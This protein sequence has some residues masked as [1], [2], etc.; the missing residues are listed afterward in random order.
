MI[1]SKDFFI[2]ASTAAHQVEGNNIHSDYW[3]ME[4]MEYSSFVEPSLDAVDHYNRYEEDIQMLADAGLN[5][6]RF[7]IEWARIEPEK[8]KFDEAEVEHYRK[9]IACCKRHGVEPIVTLHHFT[10][11]KWLICDGGWDDEMVV[12]RFAIYAK[13]IAKQLGS[14]IRYICTINEANMRLQIRAISE[15]FMKMMQA[16]M[17]ATNNSEAQPKDKKEEKLEGQ[18]Q[19]GINL[20]DPMERMKLGAMENAKIFGTP[21]PHTFVSSASDE[22]DL[23][24]CKAH[25][26]AKAAIKSVRPEIKVGITLSVHDI[27]WIEGGEERAKAEWEEEFSHYVPYIQ[28]DDFFGLQNY[29]RSVY[30]PDGIE[31]APEGAALTQMDYEVYPEALEHVIRK[32]TGEL[33][34]M[35]IMITE[36]GIG[37]NDDAQ[38]IAFI[39]VALDG[40]K[41]CMDDGIPVI[42]YCHWSLMDNFEW[43][44]GYQMTFGLCAVDRT[45][46]ERKPKE[47]LAFLGSYCK[48]WVI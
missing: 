47:S 9:V 15:R 29:T 35:P 16:K 22:G 31:A 39:K 42:G 45:T 6:Y 11:P 19:V 36:N 27:Q 3:A 17:E 40:V 2:G 14:E 12:E 10:S 23:L 18:V 8:D 21:Q 33:P 38:R 37:T 30:G 20:S 4:Q 26:A 32:V 34:G 1:F 25:Q 5:A 13:Y 7:S 48:K 46:Q 44:K 28:E 43:Q 41:N 24:V